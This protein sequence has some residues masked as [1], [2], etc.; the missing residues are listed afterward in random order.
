MSQVVNSQKYTTEICK[1]HYVSC[2]RSSNSS[3]A[4]V[5][6]HG[7]NSQEIHALSVYLES[8]QVTVDESK[9]INVNTLF[10]TSYIPFKFK[11]L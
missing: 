5:M 11:L 3:T 7:C 9:C 1:T 8:M 4:L 6:S 2:Y 10:F